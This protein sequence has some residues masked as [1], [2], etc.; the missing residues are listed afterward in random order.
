MILYMANYSELAGNIYTT[1]NGKQDKNV[2]WERL[3][4]KIS[5][6]GPQKSAKQVRAV[7]MVLLFLIY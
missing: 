6:C 5:E 3:D 1:C 4:A 2:Q 7:S